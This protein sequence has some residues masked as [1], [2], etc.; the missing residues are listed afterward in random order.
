MKTIITNNSITI[1]T[2]NESFTFTPECLV[3]IQE[4]NGETAILMDT[5]GTCYNVKGNSASKA[6]NNLIINGE[7][8]RKESLPKLTEDFVNDYDFSFLN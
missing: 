7:Y 2:A 4:F 3:I 1:E 6:F 5:D 8:L